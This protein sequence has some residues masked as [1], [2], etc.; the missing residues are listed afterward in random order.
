MCHYFISAALKQTPVT[1]IST[2]SEATDLSPHKHHN[3]SNH[4]NHISSAFQSVEGMDNNKEQ[5]NDSRSL[6]QIV[7]SLLQIRTILEEKESSQFISDEWKFLAKVVDRCMFWMTSII[8]I[9]SFVYLFFR[10]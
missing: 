5:L 4:N 7:L 2:V 1:G 9:T 3:Q 10:S 8:F 6:K